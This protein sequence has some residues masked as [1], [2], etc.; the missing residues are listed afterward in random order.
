MTHPAVGR[1]AGFTYAFALYNQR[2]NLYGSGGVPAVPCRRDTVPPVYTE[3]REWLDA[4]R[5]DAF[6]SCFE[7]ALGGA[8]YKALWRP[9]GL[10]GTA[11]AVVAVEDGVRLDYRTGWETGFLAG[12]SPEI[13]LAGRYHGLDTVDYL[14]VT[15]D[16]PDERD[17]AFAG[18]LIQTL[19]GRRYYLPVAQG[20]ERRLFAPLAAGARGAVYRVDLRAF[21]GCYLAPE[22]KEPADVSDMTAMELVFMDKCPE[23]GR[24]VIRRLTPGF[25]T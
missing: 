16:N 2:A 3:P 17:K 20:E 14:D 25:W 12:V 18:I 13:A 7:C 10:C 8:G 22:R 11:E 5:A 15:V 9:G 6:E 19:R 21:F 23:P 24:I 1:A 4:D